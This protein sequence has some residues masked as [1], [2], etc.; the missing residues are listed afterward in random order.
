MLENTSKKLFQKKAYYESL[1]SAYAATQVLNKT[2]TIL[3]SITKISQ[4]KPISTKNKRQIFSQHINLVANAFTQKDL[5][6]ITKHV[7]LLPYQSKL[8]NS[9]FS[10]YIHVQISISSI[11]HAGNQATS[12]LKIEKL[13]AENNEEIIPSQSWR[14][15]ELT[16]Q[17]HNKQ[18]SKFE[19]K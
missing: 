7:N 13:I 14:K 15:I 6:A 18:W 3:K 9:I 16:A 11:A 1:D 19:W 2:L 12:V 5:D 8:L 10:E 4:A 17:F